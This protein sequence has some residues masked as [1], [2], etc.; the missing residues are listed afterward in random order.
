MNKKFKN[1]NIEECC[2]FDIETTS[3]NEELDLN[4]KEFELWQWKNRDKVT[5]EFLTDVELQEL[6]K[7]TAALK[8]GYNKIV[9]IG[10][11]FVRDG[12]VRIKSL[13]GSEEDIIKQ[14]CK[15][16]NNFKYAVTFNGILFDMPVIVTNG[17]KYF[18]IS[19]ELK[20][21]FN[22]SQKKEWH[23]EKHQ[24]LMAVVKGS[25]Y[26]NISFDEACYMFGVESP[27]DDIKGSEVTKTYYS[28]GI[29]RIRNY[30]KKDVF[31]L[32]QLF[33]ALRHEDKFEN[34]VD[35]DGDKTEEVNQTLLQELYNTKNFSTD[36]QERLRK[37]LKERKMLKKEI[38]TVEKLL[39]SHYLDKIEI[40]SF[41][42]KE[43]EAINKER[44]KEIKEF[45]KTL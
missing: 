25:H 19:S 24:D 7:K 16:I 1:L 38:K 33:R 30:V 43:T 11:G 22:T 32:V 8:I 21:D 39:L 26:N 9:T 34:F 41:D 5:G 27:K 15:I 6:Y 23:L 40:T 13:S 17:N 36:F 35:V 29:D 4:S 28:G 20:D 14:F 31:A 45:I 42:K 37:Q 10:V 18:D 12:E 2:F 44:E 3:Q